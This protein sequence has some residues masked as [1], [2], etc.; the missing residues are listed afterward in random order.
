MGFELDGAPV[1][2]DLFFKNSYQTNGGWMY[3]VA[4]TFQVG[5][6]GGVHGSCPRR[7]SLSS[8]G[9]RGAATAL[10]AHDGFDL[11]T[12]AACATLR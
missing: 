7:A 9:L 10:H 11:G 5:R 2:F 1:A 12:A 6:W 8:W 4:I 3:D